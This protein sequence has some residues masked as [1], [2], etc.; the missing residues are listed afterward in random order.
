M[1]AVVKPA[2]ELVNVEIDG[3]AVAVPKGSMIIHASDELGAPI[4][5]FCYHK[6]LPIAANCRMCL[7]E[8]EKSAKP[9]P[10]CATPVMEGMKVHTRSEKALKSQRN[11]MEF[12]LI[13]HPLDCPICDQGGEC[14]LQDVAMGYGRSVSRF[15]E[16]KRV[17]AD[18]NLGP[19]I[20][21][22]MTR[23]I[24]CTRCVRF[25]TEIAG[26]TELGGLGRGENLE[27]GTYIGKSIESEIGGNI[28]DVCPVGALTNKVF[29]Y[30]ARAWEL[31]ARPS[32]GYHD[33]LHSNLFL[34]VRRGEVLRVVPRDNE[35]INESWLSDRDRYSHQG[36]QSADRAMKPMLREGDAWRDASW[37]EALTRAA[38]ILRD[39]PLG[40]TGF[41]VGGATSC[42]EGALLARVAAHLGSSHL[43]HRLGQSDFADDGTRSAQPGF[44]MP[45]ADVEAADVIVLV[46]C[47][48][49]REAPLLA[50]RIRKACRAG[51]KVFVINP[52]DLDF[53]FPLAGKFIATPSM[54]PGKLA[55]LAS[56]LLAGTGVQAPPALAS[57]ISTAT[58]D[59]RDA[60]LAERLKNAERAVVIVGDLANRSSTA[61]TL[62]AL[63][64]S[65]ATAAGAAYNLLPSASNG[66]G[67]TQSGVVPGKGGANAAAQLAQPLPAYVLYGAETLDFAAPAVAERALSG[68]KTIVFTAF[69]DEAMK[70]IADVILPIGLL[71]EIDATLVNVDGMVQH[72]APGARLPGDARPGW[73]ALR[74]LG[75]LLG[76]KGFDYNNIGELRDGIAL[77]L[78]AAEDRFTVTAGKVET[79]EGLERI[80]SLPIYRN[81]A[82]VRRSPALQSTPLSTRASVAIHPEQARKT[83]LETGHRVRVDHPAGNSVDLPLQFDDAVPMGA[84]RIDAG[85]A[86]T[87]ALPATGRVRIEGALT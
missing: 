85:F 13:N 10:A 36:L 83:G 82:V 40:Q 34:H 31:S 6:K 8:V 38:D 76:A 29:R 63:A 20:A 68:A 23:C 86:E 43:D 30:K 41:L 33:A 74:V 5:R 58:P 69:V 47:D 45:L 61:S 25:M 4:P 39:A 42:E 81:D 54:L 27:I 35:S 32:V 52:L 53:N 26:T 18:E 11:V 50:H 70:R 56:S 1:N 17:V 59:D 73:R 62:R 37:E 49:R 72:V 3:T 28:I 80:A 19:L 57:A 16:R 7:V 14:E 15:V 66:V 48:P 87:A 9:M 51:A 21:T 79:G 60:A 84:V 64:R 75:D 55:A 65:I 77:S 46:G 78:T 22:D 24:H 71:P 12:L 44:Q 67:L 2:V